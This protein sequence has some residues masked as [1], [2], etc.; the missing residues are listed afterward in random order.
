MRERELNL[1]L[2]PLERLCLTLPIKPISINAYQRNTRTGKRIKTGKG[3]AF[4]EEIAYRLK[5]YSIELKEFGKL[6]DPSKV[7]VKLTLRVVNSNYFLKDGSRISKTAGDVDNYI[8]VLQ[9][10]IFREI[11]TDDYIMRWTDVADCY[12]I[13]DSTY[14]VL[15]TFPIPQGFSPTGELT[16]RPIP[17]DNKN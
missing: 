6:L 1:V 2:E 11:G 4:D 12:G 7:I 3:L 15:E 16:F 14:I 5:D 9:D 10:K 17:G 8:K 13:E